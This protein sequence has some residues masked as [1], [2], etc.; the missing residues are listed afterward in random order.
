MWIKIQDKLYNLDHVVEIEVDKRSK[1][2]FAKHNMWLYHDKQTGKTGS[3]TRIEFIKYED[4]LVVYKDI[5]NKV[6][7]SIFEVNAEDMKRF[8]EMADEAEKDGDEMMELYGEYE[9]MENEIESKETVP[10]YDL[11]KDKVK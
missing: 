2:P 3:V 10:A 7:L 6:G 5:L 8:D 9:E 1:N 11:G 4:M